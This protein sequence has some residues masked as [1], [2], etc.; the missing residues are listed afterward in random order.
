MEEAS[1]TLAAMP[2]IGEIGGVM[3]FFLSVCL[4]VD[5]IRV[6]AIARD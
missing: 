2:N 5:S 6:L 3:V 4:C 1:V